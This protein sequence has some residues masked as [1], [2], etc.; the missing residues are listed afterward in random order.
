MSEITHWQALPSEILQLITELG[1][2][3]ATL[4]R[5]LSQVCRS[6]R[7]CIL[8][9]EYSLSNLIFSKLVSKSD[10]FPLERVD[11]F[12]VFFDRV[13]APKKTISFVRVSSSNRRCVV[14]NGLI[15]TLYIYIFRFYSLK[16]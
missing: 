13:S 8:L 12:S 15:I 14:P 5:T 3:D 4:A 10:R 1:G 7:A 11:Y 6:W 2:W 16:I 9:N